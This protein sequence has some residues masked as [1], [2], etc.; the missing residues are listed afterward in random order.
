MEIGLSIKIKAIDDEVAACN[1]RLRLETK[2]AGTA[3]KSTARLPKYTT[4]K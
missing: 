1:E 2:S 4:E 3:K